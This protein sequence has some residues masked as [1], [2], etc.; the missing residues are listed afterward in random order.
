MAYDPK[1]FAWHRDALAARADTTGQHSYPPIHNDTPM[2]GTYAYRAAKDKAPKPVFFWYS[3]KT[4]DLLCHLDGQPVKYGLDLWSGACRNP[5]SRQVYDSVVKGEPWPHEIRIETQAGT[6]STLTASPAAGPGHNSGATDADLAALKGNIEEWANRIK[7]AARKGAPKTQTDAD[8]IADMG[9]KLADLLTEGE[10]RRK[11][12]TDPLWK[13]YKDEMELWEFLKPNAEYVKAAKSLVNSFLQAENKR[14][15]DEARIANAEAEAKRAAELAKEGP[16]TSVEALLPVAPA[17]PPPAVAGTRKKV[18]S[19]TVKVVKFTD[20]AKAAAFFCTME[21]VP[22]DIVEAV[23][24]SAYT[25]LD[26]G[27]RVP[28]AELDTENVAK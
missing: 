26:N 13:A 15:A 23:K 28:G 22:P 10:K 3:S 25:L 21:K 11:A 5:I 12:A 27:V 8:A 6:D 4:G 16:V 20:F 2:T 18:R 7:L 1:E 14:R 24:R 19:A 9:T 17:T